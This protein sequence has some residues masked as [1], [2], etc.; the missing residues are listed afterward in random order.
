M[1]KISK[2]GIKKFVWRKLS[3]YILY[4]QSW[5]DHLRRKRL[6][7]LLLAFCEIFSTFTFSSEDITSSCPRNHNSSKV[8]AATDTHFHSSR[9]Y[10]L[11]SRPGILNSSDFC[12]IPSIHHSS[13]RPPGRLPAGFRPTAAL[14]YSEFD[15]LVVCPNYF[16]LCTFLKSV[17]PG[18]PVESRI[19]LVLLPRP[20]PNPLSYGTAAGGS[21]H[22]V[23]E[24]HKILFRSAI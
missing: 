1:R 20:Y 18:T 9:S 6:S 2:N 23:F 5:H 8:S 10:T 16:V 13:G 11:S 7:D 22:F 4:F 12:F 14:G 17:V 19:S 3:D 21:R 24:R 15:L